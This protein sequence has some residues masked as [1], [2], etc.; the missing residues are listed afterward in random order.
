M[1]RI[2]ATL[3]AP[4]GGSARV[5]GH[6]VVRDARRVR[7]TVSLTGQYASVDEEPIIGAL[8]ADLFRYSVAALIIVLLGPARRAG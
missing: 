1:V 2:L 4:T 8:V 6:D 7:E 3:I 5:F